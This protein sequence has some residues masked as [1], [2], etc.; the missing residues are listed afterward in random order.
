MR[1]YPIDGLMLTENELGLYLLG[2]LE[3]ESHRKVRQCE[4][5][6]VPEMPAP[7][8]APTPKAQPRHTERIREVRAK[9]EGLDL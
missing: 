6:P 5:L 2:Q 1:R 3:V 4:P 7:T 9:S 8:A